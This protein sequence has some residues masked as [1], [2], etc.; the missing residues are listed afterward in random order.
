VNGDGRDEGTVVEVVVGCG[1][2]VVITVWTI[3]VSSLVLCGFLLWERDE[4]LS[5]IVLLAFGERVGASCPDVYEVVVAKASNV[6]SA[7]L[8]TSVV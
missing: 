6:Y 3:A 4:I 5:V 8:V 7:I 2:N 1:I